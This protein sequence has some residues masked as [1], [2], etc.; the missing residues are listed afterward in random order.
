MCLRLSTSPPCAASCNLISVP[1]NG[2]FLL[3]ACWKPM[4]STADQCPVC[5]M[6]QVGSRPELPDPLIR[7]RSAPGSFILNAQDIWNPPS[8][9]AGTYKCCRRRNSLAANLRCYLSPRFLV[10][11][12]TLEQAYGPRVKGA[13][14]HFYS[15]GA[16]HSDAT[17]IQNIEPSDYLTTKARAL[18]SLEHNSTPVWRDATTHG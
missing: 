3:T 15:V 5:W 6:R 4:P 12:G 11:T 8:A 18:Q 2:A 1:T 17:G 9:V 7:G 16:G 13:R 14:F 10:H